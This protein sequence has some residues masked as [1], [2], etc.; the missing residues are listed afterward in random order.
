MS[1]SA[2]QIASELSQRIS[3]LESLSEI[4]LK[5]EMAQLKKAIIEN[6]AAC[7]LLKEE[8]IGQMVTSLRK[9]TGQAIVLATTKKKEPKAAAAPKKK[10]TAAEL[11]AALDS[12]DW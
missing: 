8:D 12:E 5:G 4:D 9:I 1:D 7:L 6:P 3:Q 11:A 10:M 2:E